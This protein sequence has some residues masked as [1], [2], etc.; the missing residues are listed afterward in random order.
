MKIYAIS[1]T[2]KNLQNEKDVQT[3]LSTK[4]MKGH[5]EYHKRPLG[6]LM[7]VILE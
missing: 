5:M 2:M 7:V 3:I 4:L 1:E 6:G